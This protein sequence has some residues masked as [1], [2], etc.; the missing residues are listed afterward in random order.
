M[1]THVYGYIILKTEPAVGQPLV[2]L[3]RRGKT[4]P[5]RWV[6]HR[7]LPECY[8]YTHRA[9]RRALKRDRDWTR[10]AVL[11][12]EAIYNPETAFAKPRGEPIPFGELKSRLTVAA[13]A[14]P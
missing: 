6:E 14:T 1:S 13:S 5:A 2:A 3:S 4:L 11:V 10:E 9:I 8:V 7:S 12:I